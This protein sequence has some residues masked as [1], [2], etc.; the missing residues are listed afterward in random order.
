M[1]TSY[2]KPLPIITDDNR[3]YWEYCKQHELRM[4]QC[5]DCGYIRFP[6]GIL[7]PQCHSMDAGWVKL[8]G[9]GKIYSFVV[10]RVS[11]HPSYADDIPY[12]VVVIQLAEGP[13]MESNITGIKVEDLKVDTP[14]EVYF[15]DV[16]D[17]VSLPK[18]KAVS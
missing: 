1:M 8:S 7:C 5:N 4:Q 3:Q 9:R 18:F 14:V 6:P 10:Y 17:E 16:T 2:T 13:R 12:A 15:D 11:Y